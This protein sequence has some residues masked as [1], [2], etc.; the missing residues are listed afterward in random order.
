MVTTTAPLKKMVGRRPKS[1]GMGPNTRLDILTAA[2]QVF[3]QKGYD[4]TSVREVAEMAGVNK[5]MIYYHFH[6]KIDLYRAVLSYSFDAMQQ[7]WDHEVFK[8]TASAREKLHVF[9]EGFIR[10]QHKNEDFRKILT[11]EFAISGAK[12]ENMKWITKHY[13]S[14]NH[15]ALVQIL[16]VGMKS[17]EL[18]NMNPLMA[19]VV[20]F[21]MI[22]HSFIFMPIT[23]VIDGEKINISAATLSTFITDLFFYGLCTKPT[24]KAR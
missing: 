6:D 16:K 3:A 9:I 5:A 18:R 20:L 7:I 17:G 15:A 10:F 1:R 24:A 4:G 19:I 22:I 8:K 12:S 13:S 14:K 23:P 11:M 2:R 21:G